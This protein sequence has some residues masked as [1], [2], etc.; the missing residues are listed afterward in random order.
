MSIDSIARG[1]VLALWPVVAM[2]VV[3]CSPQDG[4]PRVPAAAS[5]LDATNDPGCDPA[6]P[7]YPFCAVHRG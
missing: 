4:A 3:S 6:D 7:L 1:V 2:T 5:H